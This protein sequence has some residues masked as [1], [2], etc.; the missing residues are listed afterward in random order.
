MIRLRPLLLLALCAL[1]AC[2]ND[3]SSDR[4]VPLAEFVRDLGASEAAAA[5]IERQVLQPFTDELARVAALT[6]GG[7]FAFPCA[8]SFRGVLPAPENHMRWADGQA[9]IL[10]FGAEFG[11]ALDEA[12]DADDFRALL[13]D[14]ASGLGSIERKAFELDRFRLSMDGNAATG[15]GDLLLAGGFMSGERTT[16]TGVFGLEFVRAE[17]GWLLGAAILERATSV[18]T[19]MEPFRDVTTLTGFSAFTS[20][21]NRELLQRL[22]DVRRTQ[23]MGGLT[24]VDWNKDGFPDVL[25]TR[26]GQTATLLLNDARGGFIPAPLPFQHPRECPAMALVVDLDGDGHDEIVGSWPQRYEEDTATLGLWTRRG[27]GWK[28]RPS[29]LTFPNPRGL[30]RLA[31]Q[32]V[33]PFDADDDGDLDLFVA[34]YGNHLSRS[35]HYNSVEAHDG[36]DNHL[37][38]NEGDLQFREVSLERGIHGTQYTYVALA[39]DFD[40]DGDLDLFEGND[41]GPNVMW[42]NDGEG[43]FTADTALGFDRERG[44]SMGATLGDPDGEGAWNLYVSNMS[45]EQGA[46]MIELANNVSQDMVRSLEHIAGGN[47]L[48]VQGPDGWPNEAQ[49]AEC[50]EA[51]WAWGCAF[52][53]PDNDGDRD[54]IVTNGFTSHRS[55]EQ[56]WQTYYWRQVLKDA[57]LLEAGEPTH[58]VNAGQRFEGSFNGYERDRLFL[59]PDGD[60]PRKGRRFVEAAWN[61][62][63]DATHD[64]RAVAPIDFDGDGDLD[65]ALWTLQ[66]LRLLENRLPARHFVRLGLRGTNGH[67]SALGATVE[68]RAGNRLQRDHVKWVEGFQTQVLGELHFGL[69]DFAGPVD[70]TVHWPGGRRQSWEAVPTGGFV[71]LVEGELGPRQSELKRWPQRSLR[72]GAAPLGEQVVTALDGGRSTLARSG[73]P[74]VVR[75]GG[76]NNPKHPWPQAHVLAQGENPPHLVWLP[77]RPNI[78][79][80]D[81]DRVVRILKPDAELFASLMGADT[82]SDGVLVFDRERRLARMFVGAP[83]LKDLQALLKALEEE[84]PFVDLL[85]EDGRSLLAQ[86]R[87]R[88]AGAV[89]LRATSLDPMRTDVWDGLAQHHLAFSRTVRAREA[90]EKALEFDPDYAL[91]HFN[92]GVNTQGRGLLSK[93]REHLETA[94]LLS[95]QDERMWMVLAEVAAQQGELERTV[96]AAE[97]ASQLTRGAAPRVLQGK[98]LGQLRRLPEAEAAFQDALARDPDA[99]EARSA[100]RKVQELIASGG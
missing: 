38:I 78:D 44:Y 50:A 73:K 63:L 37:F 1:S 6:E 97:Q 35:K 90:W 3:L 27:R 77:G 59:N 61:F 87:F 2:G 29:A 18:M 19:V 11:T 89:F 49:A 33:V 85:V 60:A 69:G 26:G 53:D 94:V 45:S 43:H 8:E 28:A 40:E 96:E 95:P 32:T 7:V 42:S 48:H 57:Q 14:H 74:T 39:F 21:E 16:W 84:E 12:L 62:G 51:E 30:R 79:G 36:G 10:E 88:E 66:G 22:I 99:S 91:G 75:V 56:D 23:A 70:I 98:A 83:R 41:F 80:H 52:W 55:M 54:L 20:T 25:A 17:S 47:A 67:A 4:P 24:V 76:T 15:R 68:V 86:G 9:T 5:D 65:L 34:V 92:L 13:L 100:L 82:R 46:R 81:I 93:S 72:E 64:G 58:N 31:I 71:E